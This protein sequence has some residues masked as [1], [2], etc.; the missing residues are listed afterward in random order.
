M[1]SGI[2]S[3]TEQARQVK[4]IVRSMLIAFLDNEG[5]VHHEYVP[6]GQTVKE[7]YKT[8]LQRLRE[9][10]RRHLPEKWLSGNWI[11]HHDNAPAHGAIT[12]N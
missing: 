11:L 10:V 1:E 4:S 3:S 5:L 7:F 8:V 9:A 2:V 6:R 12:I